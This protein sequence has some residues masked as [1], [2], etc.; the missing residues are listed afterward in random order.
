MENEERIVHYI[1]SGGRMNGEIGLQD[2][3][4]RFVKFWLGFS[5]RHITF[6]TNRFERFGLS[7]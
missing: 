5:K 1:E 2:R 7:R 4:Q 6:F 3:T